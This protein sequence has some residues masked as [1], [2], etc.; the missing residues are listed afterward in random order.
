MNR[1][2]RRVRSP[3]VTPHSFG[4][5]VLSMLV[6]QT[7]CTDFFEMC[8]LILEYVKQHGGNV[9]IND[10]PRLLEIGYVTDH[11]EYP[12]WVIKLKDLKESIFKGALPKEDLDRLSLVTRSVNG[13]AK[14]GWALAKGYLPWTDWD[15]FDRIQGASNA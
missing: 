12:W 2:I 5:L 14:I 15:Q 13:R 6:P 11:E 1:S 9:L 3:Y 4:V 8:N 7:R 10:D